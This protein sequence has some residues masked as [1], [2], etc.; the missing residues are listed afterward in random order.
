M[1]RLAALLMPL[2]LGLAVPD[3]RASVSGSAPLIKEAA[4][5]SKP[6]KKKAAK[7]GKKAPA[8][9]A[10][11]TVGPDSNGKQVS[12]RVGQVLAVKL[13][14]NPTTGFAWKLAELEGGALVALGDP[15]F[16]RSPAKAK[17]VGVGGTT[18]ARFRA[19]EEG[20]CVVRLDY[21]RPWEKEPERAFAVTIEVRPAKKD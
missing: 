14:G 20:T 7:A 21:G 12:L 11:V 6:A 2:S 4:K 9:K 17:A 3:C 13:P 15:A 10:D 5:A 16:E 8:L 18:T 19:V 1:R